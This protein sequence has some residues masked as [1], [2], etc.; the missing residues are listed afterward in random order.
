MGTCC[1]EQPKLMLNFDVNKTIVIS[2][3]AKNI[4]V[5]DCLK[6]CIAEN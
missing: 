4:G 5:E 3:K 1:N 6:S 2:D